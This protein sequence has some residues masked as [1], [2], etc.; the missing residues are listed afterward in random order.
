MV[1]LAKANYRTPWRHDVGRAGRR[2]T[3]WHNAVMADESSPI[4]QARQAGAMEPE[5]LE[6]LRIAQANL[7]TIPLLIKVANAVG[8][9]L[10]KSIS[11]LP[12][13]ARK[14]IMDATRAALDKGLAWA[15][16]TIDVPEGA[17]SHSWLHT[18]VVTASGGLGGAFGWSALAVELPF[19][20]MVMLRSIAAIAREHGEDLRDEET[21]LQCL[22][23]L[24]YGGTS[25][26]DDAA[27]TTYYGTR[28]AL[29]TSLPRVA[30]QM[31]TAIRGGDAPRAARVIAAFI[32]KVASRFGLVVQEKAIAQSVPV[33]GALGGA[34][35]NTLFIAHF[36]TVARGH[37]A[38]RRLE[39]IYGE[40]VVR[41]AYERLRS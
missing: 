25:S 18:T 7:E 26:A 31:G 8:Q 40:A 5:H 23:V 34:A 30:A 35:L 1:V 24:A 16:A 22:A 19:S 11:A 27:E 15:V 9:P 20:T 28:A 4:P 32:N 10:E 3:G 21:R 37:F 38:V 12:E 39:R 13:R 14:A 33:V 2:S 36:Q 6:Q 17:K 41:E 29:A